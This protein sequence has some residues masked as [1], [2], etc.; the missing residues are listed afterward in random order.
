MEALL[1]DKKSKCKY[2]RHKTEGWY[3]KD[4]YIC[5]GHWE[6]NKR[7][8]FRDLPTVIVSSRQL[9]KMNKLI[10]DGENN[11]V[12]NSLKKRRLYCIFKKQTRWFP[13]NYTRRQW[14]F[15]L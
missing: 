11:C 1:V 9:V 6:N 4:G 2:Q 8:P 14:N 13:K 3:W 10:D 15:E 12:R 5:A 7:N